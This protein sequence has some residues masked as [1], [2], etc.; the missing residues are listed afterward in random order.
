M[1]DVEV[2]AI[3]IKEKVC[4]CYKTKMEQRANIKFCVK[5]EKK[6]AD[7]RIDTKSLW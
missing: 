7:I 1:T 5:L 6:L 4:Q 3:L 2:T